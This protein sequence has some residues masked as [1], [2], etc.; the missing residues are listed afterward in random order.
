MSEHVA[1]NINNITKTINEAGEVFAD[2]HTHVDHIMQE[3]N[4][5]NNNETQSTNNVLN[6][7]TN[8]VQTTYNLVQLKTKFGQNA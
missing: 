4:R 7:E 3:V 5:I 1:H 8:I 6:V 2:D